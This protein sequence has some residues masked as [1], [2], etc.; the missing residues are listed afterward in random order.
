MLGFGVTCDKES[1]FG[2]MPYSVLSQSSA[3][4]L[5]VCK[6][7]LSNIQICKLGDPLFSL[8]VERPSLSVNQCH[9]CYVET[10]KLTQ[11]DNPS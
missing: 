6:K 4:C 3:K 10:I 7:K 2:S 11:L 5:P 9:Y 8:M 1:E